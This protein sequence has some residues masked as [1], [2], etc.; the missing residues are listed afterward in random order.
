MPFREK[1]VS[2]ATLKAL[3]PSACQASAIQISAKGGTSDAR[4]KIVD[5][6]PYGSLVSVKIRS[7]EKTSKTDAVTYEVICLHP[8][9][10]TPRGHVI[11]PIIECTQ[12]S[13]DPHKRAHTIGKAKSVCT[14]VPLES[15]GRIIYRHL[16]YLVT[17]GRSKYLRVRGGTVNVDADRPVRIDNSIVRPLRR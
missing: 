11:A 15:Q 3:W 8:C 6:A 5:G 7:K 10:S 16:T 2:D 12:H 17:D 1:M 14:V 9:T 13:A 4:I